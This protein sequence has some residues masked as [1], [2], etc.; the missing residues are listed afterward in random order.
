MNGSNLGTCMSD[1]SE[2]CRIEK[3]LKALCGYMLAKDP[4]TFWETLGGEDSR[5]H[6]FGAHFGVVAVRDLLGLDIPD[7][8]KKEVCFMPQPSTMTWAEGTFENADGRFAAFW[9]KDDHSFRMS[10]SAP[11]GY[12]ITA[13]LPKDVRFMSSVI[14]NDKCERDMW[15]FTGTGQVEVSCEEDFYCM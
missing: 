9:Q 5:D 1:K 15:S 11:E 14:C 6:G 4:G 13:V 10:I 7:R 8:Q 12:R 3:E 2:S